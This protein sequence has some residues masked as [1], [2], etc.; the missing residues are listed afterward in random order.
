[1]AYSEI[2]WPVSLPQR[3]LVDSYGETPD[4]DVIVT[5]M[6]AGDVYKRQLQYFLVFVRFICALGMQMHYYL[7]KCIL[8]LRLIF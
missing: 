2:T 4:Y 8:Q 7:P 3:P 5:D 6:D 1:M